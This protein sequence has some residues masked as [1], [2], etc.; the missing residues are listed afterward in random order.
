M[1]ALRRV[2]FFSMLVVLV[3]CSKTSTVDS[4]AS[5]YPAIAAA[6]G[7]KIDP[8]NLI[9][10]AGQ[11]VPGYI[12]NDHAAST[13][14][15]N[16]K[17]TLGRVLFYDKALSID[18][19]VSCAS[20]HKQ[21][22]AF[23]DTAVVSRGVAGALTTRHS[24]RLINVQFSFEKK[25]FWDERAA[26]LE[27]QTTMPIKDHAEMGFSGQ[28]GRP[29]FDKLLSK[30]QG[31]GYYK[32]LFHLVYGDQSITEIRMQEAM[33]H[34]I[35]SIRSFDSKY[36]ASRSELGDDAPF[37]GF[38]AEENRGKELFL[39]KPQFDLQGSRTGG[40]LGCATCHQPPA[41]NIDNTSKNNGVVGVANSI[42]FDF[43]NTKSPTLRD[44]VHVDGTVNGPMMHT[45]GI[46]D[47]KGVLNHYNAIPKIPENK[48]I[49]EKLVP[50]GFEQRL[51]LN[52]AEINAT[53][54]FL[55]TLSGT[56]VYTDARWSNPFQ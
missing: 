42:G 27:I 14:T 16:K 23:G 31:I 29:A 1:P 54:A 35:R 56:K 5:G 18:N 45:G 47:L 38:T 9:D 22:F 24:M 3:G 50:Y 15:N 33:A 28:N 52:P 7:G 43:D 6:F 17:A 48:S 53:I 26:N 36:D 2:L 46:K 13:P 32:E 34:F 12:E 39:G 40:G 41:F 44:L 21:Q 19:S 4:P 10:Y 25:F 11:R 8:Q 51:N 30:L 37:P 49:S 55:R 20:C